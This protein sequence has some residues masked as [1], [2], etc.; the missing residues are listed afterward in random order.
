MARPAEI[1]Q[2]QAG[3]DSDHWAGMQGWLVS[4]GQCVNA[5]G[6]NSY[7]GS[8]KPAS[9]AAR[10]ECESRRR[11]HCRDLW[12][13]TGIGGRATGRGR[14][15]RGGSCRV[16]VTSGR[17]RARARG[18]RQGRAVAQRN[19][20]ENDAATPK[21]R[22]LPVPAEAG[23]MV[24][25]SPLQGSR[26]GAR[27]PQGRQLDHACAGVVWRCGAPLATTKFAD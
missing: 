25:R 2:F 15:T 10:T 12:G 6:K 18:W 9:V 24:T 5:W 7:A 8:A 23:A 19:S 3:A 11:I 14:A 27:C 1:Q 16:R 26:F 21:R 17:C 13:R 4:S 22:G 20:V